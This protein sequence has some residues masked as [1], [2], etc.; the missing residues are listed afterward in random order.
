MERL[1][2]SRKE[3]AMLKRMVRER[4]RHSWVF[5]TVVLPAII[6]LLSGLLVHLLTR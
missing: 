4:L 6:S 5:N 2:R 1:G 3:G